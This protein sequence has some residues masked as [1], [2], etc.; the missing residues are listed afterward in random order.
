MGL[1]HILHINIQ[2]PIG[3]MQACATDDGV[4]LLEFE[5]RKDIGRQLRSLQEHLGQKIIPGQNVHLLN[6]KL[7]LDEYFNKKRE[8]FELPIIMAGTEFQ[9]RVWNSL[10]NI[11]Y[12]QT[13]TYK[14]L[15]DKLGYPLAIRAVAGANAANKMAILIPCHRV[16]G[17]DGKLV[18]YAGG[19]WRKKYLLDLEKM[20]KEEQMRIIF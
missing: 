15:T 20:D 9:K 1:G 18:G 12:G 19:L 3:V 7:Q 13:I 2:T 6:L 8:I 4:C 11:P 16:I 10:L 17:S 14:A 5:E